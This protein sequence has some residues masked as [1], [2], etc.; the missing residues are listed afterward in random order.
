MIDLSPASVLR[1]TGTEGSMWPLATGGGK[2]Q[3]FQP[4]SQVAQV[5]NQYC[6]VKPAATCQNSRAGMDLRQ[7]IG[8]H[9]LKTPRQNRFP[10]PDSFRKGA[11]Y[12]GQGGDLRSA[13]GPDST[14]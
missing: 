5:F 13:D 2:I 6:P 8:A 4:V 7:E 1:V 11:L 3:G 12:V 14:A 9:D 10:F